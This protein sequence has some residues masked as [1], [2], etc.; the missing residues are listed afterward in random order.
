[1]AGLS[2]GK[3]RPIKNQYKKRVESEFQLVFYYDVFYLQSDFGLI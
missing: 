1:M 3:E 2:F